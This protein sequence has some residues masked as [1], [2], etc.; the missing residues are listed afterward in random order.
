MSTS[1]VGRNQLPVIKQGTY[2]KQVLFKLINSSLAA[3][4][5]L[6]SRP[7]LALWE[8]RPQCRL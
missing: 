8:L 2:F 6:V 5:A 1:K 4:V 7:T 3:A